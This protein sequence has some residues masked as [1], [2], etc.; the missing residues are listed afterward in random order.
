MEHLNRYFK[1]YEKLTPP[2]STSFCYHAPAKVNFS[3]K[4]GEKGSNNL[5]KIQSLMRK[6]GI[7]D[8]ISLN[9]RMVAMKFPLSRAGY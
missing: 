8:K 7:F 6:I 1:D 2:D 9:L 5:H 3:L 4:I